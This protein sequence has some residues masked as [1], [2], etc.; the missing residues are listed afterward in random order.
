M[1]DDLA[2]LKSALHAN[3]PQASAA[4]REEAISAAKEQFN[5]HNQVGSTSDDELEMLKSAFHNTAPKASAAVR[6]QAISTAKGEFNRRT[7]GKGNEKRL[8]DK[9]LKFS[10]FHSYIRRLVMHFSRPSLAFVGSAVALAIGIVSYQIVVTTHSPLHER[11]LLTETA[12][13]L[14]TAP[15][16][17]TSS[18]Q[19]GDS[20]LSESLPLELAEPEASVRTQSLERRAQEQSMRSYE[21]NAVSGAAGLSMSIEPSMI[22]DE[23]RNQVRFTEF[24]SNRVKLVV[25]EPVSTFSIDVD[26]TSYAFLRAM[27]NQGIVPFKDAIRTE[28]LVN[29]FPYD[30]APPDT[31]DQPFATHV[32][33]M[34]TPWNDASLIMHIGIKAF[35]P[36]LSKAPPANLVFLIDTSGSMDQPNKLPLLIRSFK[37]LLS[38]LASDDKVAIVA[39]AGSA[40]VVL[41]PT[42]VSQRSKILNSLENLYA[43][44]STAGGEGIRLAY[45]LAEQHLVADGINR[46]ILATDGDFNVGMTGVDELE[47]F[48]TRK[49]SSGVFLSVLGFGL[50]NYNDDLMQHLAQSGNGNAAYIDSISEARKVLVEQVTST[51]VTVA[52]DVKIQVEFNPALISEYRLIGYETRMLDR[53][54]FRNDKVDAGEVGAGHSVTAIYELT[55]ANT[56][57]GFIPPSRYQNTEPNQ[58]GGFD[59][60]FAFLKIRYKLPDAQSSTLVSQPVTIDDHH[61]TVNSAPRDVRF[62]AA[63]AAF[64][65]L[66]RGGRYTG[67]FGYDDV[68]GLAQGARGEDRFGYR[69]EFIRLVQMAQVAEPLDFPE[70]HLLPQGE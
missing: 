19:P 60:E 13:I 29:Y 5:L 43:G 45:S 22:Y 24:N 36:D 25:E 70:E 10:A 11:N 35:E 62:A 53:E 30:Y 2:R 51:L 52:K 6:E 48:I 49:R 63:V 65:E 61:E 66:L 57:E 40:G 33:V 41:E 69:S 18:V 28:E 31:G 4:V 59:R 37:L 8:M 46:V 32:S 68:I 38:N 54:D 55:P 23:Y 14:A 16:P 26:T 21:S 7:K 1:N 20:I 9:A 3:A 67:E 17:M 15:E 56:D 27:L 44:G 50:D 39:Y 34:P 58:S 12:E 64:G 47:E 42:P